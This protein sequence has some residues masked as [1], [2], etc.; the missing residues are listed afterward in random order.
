[1]YYAVTYDSDYTGWPL[2]WKSGKVRE[3][4]KGLVREFK[5]N[6]DSQAI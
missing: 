2:S 6:E 1:M 5:K 4:G 3:N